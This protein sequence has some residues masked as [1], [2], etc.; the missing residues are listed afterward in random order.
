[1]KSRGPSFFKIMKDYKKIRSTPLQYGKEL[2]DQYGDHVEFKIARYHV[3][4]LNTPEF[5]EY[6]LKTNY[7]NFI[8]G[9]AYEKMEPLIGQGLLIAP[10]EFW[11]QNRK[12]VNPAFRH[13]KLEEYFSEIQKSTQTLING[14]RD[15]HSYNIHQDMMQLT[16]SIISKVLFQIDLSGRSEKV[17]QA[18]HDYMYGMEEH[19]F[20]ISKF[21]KH[22]PTKT[23]KKFNNA[24]KYL[25]SIIFDL[26]KQRRIDYATQDDLISTL[27]KAQVNDGAKGITD[28]YLRDELMTFMVGGHE[29]TANALTWTFY[30]LAKNPKV[31]NELKNEVDSVLSSSYLLYEDLVKFQYMDTVINESLRITPPVWITSRE[32]LKDDEFMG[33]KLKK[34][35][36]T[37]VS[38][39]FLHH[40]PKYWTNP[41]EF[42]PERFKTD[43]NKKAFVPFGVGARSCIGEM[44]AKVELK[45]ILAL[46]IK[47]FDFRLVDKQEIMPLATITLRPSN[48]LNLELRKR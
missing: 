38:A 25:N 42:K 24:V 29:T 23:N 6:I 26:I 39:Y 40:N 7:K 37:I 20:H 36:I 34:G 3:I 5:H 11:R 41:S 43:Y 9:K 21:Q 2:Y 16:L 8:K 35:M 44:L 13:Q 33:V 27:I 19:I 47:N 14:Y 4:G 22:L 45:V 1:M 48:G 12:I 31:L 46:F 28:E 32:V 18:I 15:N 30:H 10:H 17:S